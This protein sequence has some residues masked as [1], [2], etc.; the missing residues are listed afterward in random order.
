MAKTVGNMFK[1]DKGLRMCVCVYM[2]K[3]M[4]FSRE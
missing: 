1:M 2:C 3:C 4:K